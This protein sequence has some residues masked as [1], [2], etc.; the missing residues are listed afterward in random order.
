MELLLF[1][2]D[3]DNT[4][5]TIKNSIMQID[6]VIDKMVNVLSQ[7]ITTMGMWNVVRSAVT[8]STS[9]AMVLVTLY[10]LITFLSEI[11]EKDW[12][13]L[14]LSWYFRKIV[15]L[16]FA[17]G[18]ITAAPDIVI[19]IYNFIGWAMNEY[20]IGIGASELFKNIDFKEFKAYLETLGFTKHL[21]LYIE[22]FVPVIIM[23]I[24]GLVIQLMVW[25]RILQIC[26]L[27]IISPIP[28]A[29]IVNDK[30]SGVFSFLKEV[31]AVCGQSI[32]MLL[33]CELY[34]GIVMQ[35]MSN[36]I[37]NVG[38]VWQLCLS[39]IVLLT[40]IIGSQ[41]LAKLFLGR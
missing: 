4:I 29:T 22:L 39:T 11:L 14:S 6:S 21:L 20:S 13:N 16:I 31:I 25:Y 26:L 3:P 19:T 24:V 41:K 18:L 38:S 28:M 7:D 2:M 27:A 34:K 5:Q 37:Q 23:R 36:S 30:H 8:V 12:R 35:I 40:T 32:I 15:I 9:I 10:W 33:G 17:Q 1:K